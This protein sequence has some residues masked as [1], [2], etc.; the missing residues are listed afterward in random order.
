MFDLMF[1]RVFHKILPD[2]A[3]RAGGA[4]GFLAFSRVRAVVWEVEFQ[5][6]LT[7]TSRLRFQVMLLNSSSSR[8][9][10][11]SKER[12]RRRPRGVSTSPRLFN[13][14]RIALRRWLARRP[15][16]RPPL[17]LFK[18]SLLHV[19][20]TVNHNKMFKLVLQRSRIRN[21]TEDFKE[22]TAA[23]ICKISSRFIFYSLNFP[24]RR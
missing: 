18:M 9:R 6:G 21:L 1:L 17:V 13:W 15:P 14:E 23:Q 11:S 3:A 16:G 7:L 12:T 20:Q 8:L 22:Q 10:A 24:P 2:G 5:A 19:F 4:G